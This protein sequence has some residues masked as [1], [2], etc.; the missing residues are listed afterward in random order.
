MLVDNKFI[1]VSLPRSAST[2]FYITCL[3]KGIK[4][5]HYDTI[6]GLNKIEVDVSD[7]NE[8]IA[9]NIYHA[10]E[11][12]T[13][14][15]KKFGNQYDVIS[16]KR[17]R[18]ER[19]LSLWKH[20]IDE[21]HRIGEHDIFERFTQ[22]DV[23]DILFYN[24][25]NLVNIKDKINIIKRI[26]DNKKFKDIHPQIVTMVNI[27]ITPVSQYHNNDPRIKWFDFK[28]LN[29]LEEWVSNKLGIEFKLE[30]SNSSKHFNSKLRLDETFIKKYNE[31]Y[32]IYDIPKVVKTLI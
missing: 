9:D 2:S 28:K 16:V 27:L 12:L 13:S 25:E 1:F 19:F 22:L 23:N 3:K 15:E 21:T 17:D 26:V 29:E 30:Q 18:H 10:H 4:I 31:I 8:Y 6:I 11:R 20:V 32:D 5:E 14:L 24:S 7:D